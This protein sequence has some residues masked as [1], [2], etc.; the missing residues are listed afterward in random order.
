MISVPLGVEPRVIPKVPKL[1]HRHDSASGGLRG[2]Q[3][4]DDRR[5]RMPRFPGLSSHVIVVLSTPRVTV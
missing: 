4:A 2:H 1:P 3:K 5:A